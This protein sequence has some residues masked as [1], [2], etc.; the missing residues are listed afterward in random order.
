[1]AIHSQFEFI[2]RGIPGDRD[3]DLNLT[4]KE[5]AEC[6]TSVG[7]SL[8]VQKMQPS[9]TLSYRF[10]KEAVL[11]CFQPLCERGAGNSSGHC[12]CVHL[13]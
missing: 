3:V 10:F 5:M 2:D 11:F 4:S 9:G 1:M 8:A 12:L 6:S 7:E 13:P